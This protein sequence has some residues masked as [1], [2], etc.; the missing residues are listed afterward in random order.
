MRLHRLPRFVNF[1]LKRFVFD[2]DTMSRRKVTDD[3][4]FPPSVN[5][6]ELVSPL[7]GDE[8]AAGDGEWYDLAFILVHRGQ[9]AT[10]GHYVASGSR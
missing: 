7:P 9:N 3:F 10:S 4:E 2:F 1:Q 8:A 6:G 5:L